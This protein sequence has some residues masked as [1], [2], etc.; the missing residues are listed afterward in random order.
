[1]SFRIQTCLLFFFVLFWILFICPEKNK[2]SRL[3][4][5]L[6]VLL[7]GSSWDQAGHIPLS[8]TVITQQV[9]VRAYCV[10]GWELEGF[11]RGKDWLSCSWAHS[12]PLR[13]L[14]VLISVLYWE[15]SP[16]QKYF[17]GT[18]TKCSV[19]QVRYLALMLYFLYPSLA[20]FPVSR[21]FIYTHTH[22]YIYILLIYLTFGCAGSSLLHAGFL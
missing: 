20:L 13:G 10:A 21:S 1:M 6:G 19:Y 15:T 11:E 2:L 18:W 7:L 22:T 3:K 8:D 12:P 5:S 9:Q 17:R 14:S 4:Q 16:R